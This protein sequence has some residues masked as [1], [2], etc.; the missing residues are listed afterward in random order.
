MGSELILAHDIG[1]TGNK[2]TLF[3]DDGSIIGSTFYGYETSFP[4]V[5]WAEQ[6]PLDWWKAVCISTKQL[7][8]KFEVN[9][10]NIAS[11]TFSG[12]MMGCVLVDYEGNPLR[13]AIIWAD[14]RAEQEAAMLK[15]Q[16]GMEK[17]YRITGHRISSSYSGAK[18]KWIKNNQPEL[19]QQAYKALQAK[20]FLVQRLTGQFATDY[21]DASGM[22]LLDISTK[23]W[24]EE[25]LKAW[26]IDEA[27]LPDVYPSTHVIGKVTDKAAEETGLTPG[28]PVV[29]GGGDGCCAAA[30]VGVVAEGDAFTYIGSSAWVALAT[31]KP[32]F[33]PE[34]KTYTWVHLDETKY[35]PNGTMQA[36]GAS[37][38]WIRDHLYSNEH[39]LA[40]QNDESIYHL[41]N[42]FAEQSPPG[43][44]RL[45]YLP[46]LMGERAPR[47]NPDARGTF[48]GLHVK[49]N[50][51]DMTRAVMEGVTFNLNVIL[52]ALIQAGAS[53]DKMWILGGAAKSDVWKQIFAD[54]YQLELSVPHLLDEA[55][56]MGAAITGAVGVGILKDFEEAKSWVYERE[57]IKPK[58]ENQ[59]I[60][61][62]LHDIFDQSYEQ[63]KPIYE[64]LAHIKVD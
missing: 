35:S 41:M 36:A 12:Q 13:K 34:M 30:G 10:N 18:L 6:N 26:E 23:E 20:D 60:Y 17:V 3:S 50:R 16:L 15:D 27:I 59:Q 55:T 2:A 32:L 51:S 4:K 57:V 1:T 21:S 9:P 28:T 54:V 47:W 31:E 39:K 46:Y 45:L 7:L 5:G 53:I 49:H 44:N 52:K 56:S 42:N 62:Q 58:A 33:D 25:I 40:K 29:I 11:V 63:L 48:L 37:Y 43:S 19:Y 61:Q 14:M 8:S 64:R 38:Q 24:S 22:N